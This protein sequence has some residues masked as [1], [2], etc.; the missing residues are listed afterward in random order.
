ME[1]LFDQKARVVATRLGFEVIP[2]IKA[3]YFV[4][5]I[6]MVFCCLSMYYRADFVT[7]TIVAIGFYLVDTLHKGL[8]L[9]PQ[10][11]KTFYNRMEKR[12]EV[13]MFGIVVSMVYDIVWFIMNNY[14]TDDGSPETG[15]KKFSL[16]MSYLS[17]LWRVIL[18][19]VLWKD[20]IDF[21]R[22]AHQF[23]TQYQQTTGGNQGL[24]PA[25]W[26]LPD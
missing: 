25:Y 13:L 20:Q 24:N 23:E 9:T 10:E 16:W 6:Q 8:E 22:I 26:W 4:L 11:R 7:A 17:F 15:V 21:E 5:Y 12:F 14:S 1:K 3:T 2:W 18:F 19:L